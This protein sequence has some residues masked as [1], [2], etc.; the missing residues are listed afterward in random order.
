MEQS[1]NQSIMSGELVEQFMLSCS[2]FLKRNCMVGLLHAREDC[3]FLLIELL[4]IV[5]KGVRDARFLRFLY[6]HNRNHV[7]V[8]CA[9]CNVPNKY[10]IVFLTKQFVQVDHFDLGGGSNSPAP[11]LLPKVELNVLALEGEVTN[12]EIS[13]LHVGAVRHKAHIA[14]HTVVVC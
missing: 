11:V 14:L 9:N 6:A 12:N 10:R 7:W 1:I 8:I 3:S 2:T 4:S 5:L 13:V